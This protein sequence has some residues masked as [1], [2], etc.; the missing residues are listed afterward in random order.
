M[1]EELV[2]FGTAKLA[3]EKGFRILKPSTEYVKGFYYDAGDLLN[4]DP[5]SKAYQSPRE[6]DMQEEDQD[7]GNYFLRPTQSLLQRWLR[8]IHGI[9]IEECSEHWADLHTT[10]HFKIWVIEGELYEWF[11]AN[12]ITAFARYEYALEDALYKA[13]H[14]IK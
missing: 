2:T 7:R 4:T 9:H 8:E 12:K 1:K 10:Y 5:P 3:K 13:L 6:F 11:Y 14:L